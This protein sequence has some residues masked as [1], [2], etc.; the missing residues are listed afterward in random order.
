[1]L[2][3]PLDSHLSCIFHTAIFATRLSSQAVYLIQTGSSALSNTYCG[4]IDNYSA[5]IVIPTHTPVVTMVMVYITPL[6]IEVMECIHRPINVRRSV[7]KTANLGLR[8]K[9][10]DH[11]TSTPSMSIVPGGDDS[12]VAIDTAVTEETSSEAVTK[13][14]SNNS[15][16]YTET[17]NKDVTGCHGNITTMN[18]PE[19]SYVG[20]VTMTTAQP[21]ANIT[22]HTGYLTFATLSPASDSC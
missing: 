13:E 5:Q 11:V 22:G 2:Y 14:T 6:D 15:T 4:N 21:A 16:T 19:L 17:V 8:H 20:S 18:N 9:P 12:S 3:L 10:S 1:M 7:I